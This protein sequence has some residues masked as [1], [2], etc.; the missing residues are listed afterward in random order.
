MSCPIV[1]NTAQTN[2]HNVVIA[3]LAAI[4][5][6]YLPETRDAIVRVLQI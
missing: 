5:G 1:K 2:I 6:A 3:S 4:A